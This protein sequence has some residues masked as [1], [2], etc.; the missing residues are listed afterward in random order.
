MKALMRMALCMLA[1]AVAGGCASTEVTKRESMIGKEKLPR[2]E[3]IY[4]YPFVA[5]PADLPAWSVAAGRYAEPSQLPS[6]E[7]EEVGRMIGDLVAKELAEEIREMGLAAYKTAPTRKLAESLSHVVADRS[8]T[9]L[10]RF[11][12]TTATRLGI[13]VGLARVRR[14]LVL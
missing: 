8:W 5:T 2:P 3:R 12:A 10:N 7:E 4:V 6:P 11:W 1:L 9:D 13:G 14:K